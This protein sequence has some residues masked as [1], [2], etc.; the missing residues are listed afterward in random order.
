MGIVADVAD[1]ESACE[2]AVTGLGVAVIAGLPRIQLAIATRL[3]TDRRLSPTG[4]GALDLTRR[5]AAVAGL[6]VRVITTARD[7]FWTDDQAVPAHR[8]T[9][10]GL[11]RVAM[12][13]RFQETGRAAAVARVAVCVVAVFASLDFTV[14]ARGAAHWGAS[15]TRLSALAACARAALLG[16][17]AGARPAGHPGS[18]PVYVRAGTTAGSGGTRETRRAGRGIRSRRAISRVRKETARGRGAAC[19]SHE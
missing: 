15:L 12:K 16:A 8:E 1:F 9:M 18:T 5:A 14:T 3:G 19:P 4:V 7:S 13:A 11:T 10:R 2:A 17:C 6:G